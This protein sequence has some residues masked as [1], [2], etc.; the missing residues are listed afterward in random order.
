VRQ[1]FARVNQLGEHGVIDCI[2]F[3]RTVESEFQDI[4]VID[5]ENAI[6]AVFFGHLGVREIKMYAASRSISVE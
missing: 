4:T 1:A 2:Q 5:G 3:L 6:S